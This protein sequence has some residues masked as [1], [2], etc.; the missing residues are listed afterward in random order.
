MKTNTKHW[1]NI[2]VGILSIAGYASA[3]TLGSE[4][5]TYDAS[6]N[7][8]EKSIGGKVSKM[9][10]DSSN[11]LTE[12]QTI[13]RGKEATSYDAAGRPT[14]ETSKNGQQLR[15]VSYGYGDK[16]LGTKLATGQSDFYYNAEGQLVGKQVHGDVST[17]TWDGNV[18]AADGN[19]TLT[20]EAHISGGIP[21]LV[22]EKFVV[23]SDYLGSTLASGDQHFIS[24]AYGEGLEQARFTGKPFVKELNS[25]VFEQR[26]YSADTNRWT[27]TDPSGFP[28]GQNNRVYVNGDPLSRIDPRGLEV[29]DYNTVLAKY[30]NGTPNCEVKVKI[31][32]EFEICPQAVEADIGTGGGTSGYIFSGFGGTVTD[33]SDPDYKGS[34]PEATKYHFGLAV[35]ATASK[36]GEPNKNLNGS[37]DGIDFLGAD[38][39]TSWAYE[40]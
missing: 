36:Q 24:S 19:E 11:R 29:V 5:Y 40:N 32:S 6:G 35:I 9:T 23:I 1:A 21:L 8:I 4:K 25:Y 38:T 2:T 22:S 13:D 30:N 27:V 20:N 7:I 37:A 3:A 28:D 17:Y 31:T 33:Y 16:V 39:K 15:S 12:R 14:A 26:L 18:I 34:N 10:Y